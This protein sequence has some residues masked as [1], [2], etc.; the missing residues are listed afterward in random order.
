[1]IL[2]HEHVYIGSYTDNQN[3]PG[4]YDLVTRDLTAL[5]INIP[6]VNPSYVLFR[7]KYLYVVE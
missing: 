5:K 3:Q 7:K 1:M 6:C 2:E 4:I